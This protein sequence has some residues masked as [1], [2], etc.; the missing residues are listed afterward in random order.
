MFQTD[1]FIKT[2][3]AFLYLE[4]NYTSI[5]Y[6]LEKII[7]FL[8]MVFGFVHQTGFVFHRNAEISRKSMKRFEN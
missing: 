7:I 3:D 1:H 4:V 5:K 6:F 8:L 2:F